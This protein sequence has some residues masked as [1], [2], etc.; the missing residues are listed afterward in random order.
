MCILGTIL[1]MYKYA[2]THNVFAIKGKYVGTNLLEEEQLPKIFIGKEL[3]EEVPF[4]FFYFFEKCLQS[5]ESGT[6]YVLQLFRRSH[7]QTIKTRVLERLGLQSKHMCNFFRRYG[8]DLCFSLA[9]A[10]LLCGLMS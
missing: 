1:S 4:I 8:F 6:E 2:D 5:Q 7:F 3:S 10:Q 9:S